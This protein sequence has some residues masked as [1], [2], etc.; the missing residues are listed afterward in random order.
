M[1]QCLP[2]VQ[3]R[4]FT[5]QQRLGLASQAEFRLD[6][7]ALAKRK[8]EAA[9]ITAWPDED[10]E[11]RAAASDEDFDVAAGAQVGGL[12]AQPP[13]RHVFQALWTDFRHSLWHKPSGFIGL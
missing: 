11:A 12:A 5:E 2:A 6:T 10:N 3:A 9:G 4:A 13:A 1:K 8:A 7:S